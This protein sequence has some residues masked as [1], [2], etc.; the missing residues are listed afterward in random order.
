MKTRRYILKSATG[1]GA[2]G[3]ALPNG[4]IKPAVNAV[5][6]PAHAQIS[7]PC[8][9]EPPFGVLVTVL[10]SDS[11]DNISCLSEGVITDGAY[12]TNLSHYH[13]TIP[14]QPVCD[15]PTMGGALNR[16]GVY[17]ITI[18]SP[19]YINQTISS[20]VVSQDECYTD[21]ITIEV[22]LQKN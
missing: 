22:L 20:I 18:D 7:P 14:P 2:V 4:W 9:S 19:G 5:V 15:S 16:P 12:T 13:P 8:V 6:L 11:G 21:T 10:D 1:V 17:E 3:T